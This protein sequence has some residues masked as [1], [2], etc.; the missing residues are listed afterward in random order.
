MSLYESYLE[1]IE[2]RKGMELHPKPIDDKALTNEIISQIKDIE[3]KYREDSLNHFIY[4]V[5]PGTTGAAEAKAQ[6]L[7]EVILEKITLEEISSDFALEL[8]SHMKGGPSVEVL[9]DLILD[10][11]ESIA[12]KA[13]EI[14]KTQV[15]LYEADT[16]RLRKGFT[17]GNKVVRDILESYSK[18]EFFTKLPDI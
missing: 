10:A 6:F 4:N 5:L 3:N 16:E 1:E 9:L 18:A 2:E 15:F 7:K 13:G 14:L 12:Q 17:A 11:E 8:L